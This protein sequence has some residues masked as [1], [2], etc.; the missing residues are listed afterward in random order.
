MRALILD[1]GLLGRP[2]QPT[3]PALLRVGS[4]ETVFGRQ[5]RL[6]AGRGVTEI[7]VGGTWDEDARGEVA[8]PYRTRV[9]VRFAHPGPEPGWTQPAG[10]GRP[11]GEDAVL[12][13]ADDLVFTDEVLE[14]VAADP[15]GDV[16]L[17]DPAAGDGTRLDPG[18]AGRFGSGS[19]AA[20][21]PDAL[22]VLVRDGALARI[23]G[24]TGVGNAACWPVLKL[25]APVAAQW[26][27]QLTT[28]AA[29]DP[30]PAIT[31]LN[32]V[33]KQSRIAVADLAG[34]WI[35]RAVDTPDFAETIRQARAADLAAQRT[36]CE[37]RGYVHLGREFARHGMSRVL[38]VADA[39]F[40]QL[41]LAD[42][43]ARLGVE[44]VRFDSFATVPDWQDVVAAV[45]TFRHHD[46]D[47]SSPS[48]TR[49]RSASG[50]W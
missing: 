39:G 16:A 9:A 40:D 6:L 36:I 12:V 5:V 50:S 24:A 18:S 22:K 10:S 44:L 20:P 34:R 7:L 11:V 28:A 43:L 33:A 25:S 37:T 15:H 13:I 26:L 21:A 4:G 1:G 48:G 45:T 14:L 23:T 3:D 19:L 35:D 2:S 27:T 30:A 41:E 8:R 17:Y 46:C 32:R 31:A 42:Y 49:P 29:D 47:A 38:L